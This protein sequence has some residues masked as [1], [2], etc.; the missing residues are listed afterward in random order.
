MRASQ[1]AGIKTTGFIR[2]KRELAAAGYYH[3]WRVQGC[4]GRWTTEQLL[5]GVPLTAE[6]AAAVRAGR[7]SAQ[8]PVVGRPGCRS[9]GRYQEEDTRG[10]TPQPPQPPQPV[11]PEPE[12]DRD[13]EPDPVPPPAPKPRAAKPDRPPCIPPPFVA[14]GAHALTSVSR[15]DRQLRLSGVD[16]ARLAPLAGEWF[17]RGA[18]LAEVREALTGGLPDHVHSAAGLIR[19]RLL[20][21][22]PD[23]PTFAE[24]RAAEQRFAPP[25]VQPHAPAPP[26]HDTSGAVAAARRGAAAVRAALCGGGPEMAP[27]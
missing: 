16:I 13:P 12:P 21:K 9:V 5:S 25:P 18:G 4:G 8:N 26:A 27:A 23:A 14:Q 11:P 6:E 7:P 15:T 3:E 19:N 22:M 20:R 1:L 24:Q 2:A 17:Q 10:K